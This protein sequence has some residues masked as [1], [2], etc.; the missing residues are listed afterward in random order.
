MSPEIIAYCCADVAFFGLLEERLYKPLPIKFKDWVQSESV[1]RV[2]VC[3]ESVSAKNGGQGKSKG[4]AK[5]G[6]A[7]GSGSPLVLLIISS[8]YYIYVI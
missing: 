2:N 8:L 4:A 5:V 3:L 6:H 1:K 7:E